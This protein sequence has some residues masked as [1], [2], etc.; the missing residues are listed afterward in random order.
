[1]ETNESFDAQQLL[2]L[3]IAFRERVQ[4]FH[5]RDL[6]KAIE[7]KEH[8]MLFPP[9]ISSVDLSQYQDLN[10]LKDYLLENNRKVYIVYSK[11]DVRDA[12]EHGQEGIY[13]G[14]KK[15]EKALKYITR[16]QP[17]NTFET[18]HT[19]GAVPPI[20][21][22]GL[23]TAGVFLILGLTAIL[24]NT[25]TEIIRKKGIYIIKTKRPPK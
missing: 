13:P 18:E 25:E 1:M 3:K 2:D 4:T 9:D 5:E 7:N 10:S 15:M 24:R 17:Q 6:K 11:K 23:A 22:L 12:I 19:V 21:I 16:H 14:N 20:L 8:E